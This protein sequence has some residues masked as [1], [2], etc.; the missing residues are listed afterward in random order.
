M[1]KAVSYAF[2]IGFAVIPLLAVGKNLANFSDESHS[3]DPTSIE[4]I[5]NDFTEVKINSARA[6]MGLN[7]N[8]GDVVRIHNNK[9]YSI[10]TTQSIRIEGYD[11]APSSQVTFHKSND[12]SQ[13]TLQKESVVEGLSLPAG[14]RVSLLPSAPLPPSGK[15]LRWVSLGADSTINGQ[16]YAKGT[17]LSFSP[18]SGRARVMNSNEVSDEAP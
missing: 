10:K 4:K 3:I 9:L 6:L 13:F 18:L 14:T 15:L 16:T 17:R 12:L 1:E 5:D 11:V 2:I 7:L 8:T